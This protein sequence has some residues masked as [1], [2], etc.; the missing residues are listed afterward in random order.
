MDDGRRGIRQKEENTKEREKAEEKKWDA[1]GEDAGR[2]MKGEGTP[3]SAL[4]LEVGKHACWNMRD[5]HA[6]HNGMDFE[7][8]YEGNQQTETKIVYLVCV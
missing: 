7:N 6:K 2:L 8:I 5:L 3:V 1:G 4:C